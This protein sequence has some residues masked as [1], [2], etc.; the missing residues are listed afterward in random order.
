MEDG[1]VDVRGWKGWYVWRYEERDREKGM[2]L[3]ESSS[4]LLVVL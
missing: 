3:G 4:S 1:E 2:Y